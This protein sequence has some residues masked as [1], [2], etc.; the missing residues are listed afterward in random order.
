MKFNVHPVSLGLGCGGGLA[1]GLL[2]GVL[3]T[4]GKYQ[5]ELNAEV[6]E[7]KSHYHHSLAS[8]IA[9]FDRPVT[10]VEV[11]PSV[12]QPDGASGASEVSSG[13]PESH[14]IDDDD[15]RLEGIDGVYDGDEDGYSEDPGDDEAADQSFRLAERPSVPVDGGYNPRTDY[16]RSSRNGSRVVKEKPSLGDALVMAGLVPEADGSAR[17]VDL[18]KPHIISYEEFFEDPEADDLHHQKLSIT[19]YAQDKVLVDDRDAPIPDLEGTVIAANLQN[20]GGISRDENIVFI[21]NPKL[22]IDFEISKDARAYA[23]VVLGY[24]N[25]AKAKNQRKLCSRNRSMRHI[26]NGSTITL[27][28]NEGAEQSWLIR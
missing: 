19:Y 5:R 10:S 11:Q 16:S 21:R 14:H 22:K 18:S 13:N 23:E 6:E 7:L 20:F 26:S 12:G 15:P 8:V 3:L 2:C 28:R 24:G 9:S 1:A 25:P 4:R 27:I 17:E